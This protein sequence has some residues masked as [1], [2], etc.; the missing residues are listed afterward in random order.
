MAHPRVLEFYKQLNELCSPIKSTSSSHD[1]SSE[2]DEYDEMDDDEA[3]TV[4]M[5][6]YH[7][8]EPDEYDEMDNDEGMIMYHSSLTD[9]L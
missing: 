3:I 5:S 1:H 9:G 2:P 7:S 4:T 8:N 6:R